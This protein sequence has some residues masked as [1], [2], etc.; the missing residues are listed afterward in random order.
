[1][2]VTLSSGAREG[3]SRLLLCLVLLDVVKGNTWSRLRLMLRW[4][5]HHALEATWG[6][7]WWTH[8]FG[9]LLH[10]LMQ[11]PIRWAH[12]LIS[13]PFYQ[14]TL[15][16]SWRL[17][18]LLVIPTLHTH[19]LSPIG[20]YRILLILN[21]TLL[22]VRILYRTWRLAADVVAPVTE[23]TDYVPLNSVQGLMD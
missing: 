13:C 15:I 19:T 23:F 4:L 18:L 6:T 7:S 16:I 9:Y 3:V 8:H 5:H 21:L 11:I 20:K 22:L 2:Q 10:S 14:R 1:M 12:N 17:Q